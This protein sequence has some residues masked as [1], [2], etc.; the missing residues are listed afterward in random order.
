[1][2][3]DARRPGVGVWLAV[4]LG[5]LTSTLLVAPTPAL[6]IDYRL[7]VITSTFVTRIGERLVIN[8]ATPT[9]ADVQTMLIDARTTAV[10]SLSTPIVRRQ[11]VADIVAGADFIPQA[12]TSVRGPVFRAVDLNGRSAFQLTVATSA[13]RTANTLP[14]E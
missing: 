12:T 10:V 2:P 3:R 6:A 11:T 1:M 4:V 9:V 8:V 13:T 7:N 5:V 14:G